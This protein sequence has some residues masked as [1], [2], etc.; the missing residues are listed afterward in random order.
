MPQPLPEEESEPSLKLVVPAGAFQETP[1]WTLTAWNKRIL[2]DWDAL[3]ENT[4]EEAVRC[5]NWLSQD[6][7]RP[8]PK[9]CYALR[10]HQYAGVWGYEIGSGNRVYYKPFKETKSAVVYYA[11]SHPP[12][13][14]I[15]LPPK[16]L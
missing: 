13:K 8:I 10:G 9:R 4:P 16:G 7:M 14:G 5:Y 12:G 6:A 11:G 1:A 2:K 15:P 3:C